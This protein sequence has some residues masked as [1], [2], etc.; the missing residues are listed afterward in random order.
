MEHRG[1]AEEDMLLE[2]TAIIEVGS[3]LAGVLLAAAEDNLEE[4]IRHEEATT[5]DRLVASSIGVEEHHRRNLELPGTLEQADIEE[6]TAM[7]RSKQATIVD[8]LVGMLE[9]AVGSLGNQLLH[10]EA[11]S[12][13]EAYSQ[14]RHL[15]MGMLMGKL[16]VGK[17]LA[18]YESEQIL[19]MHF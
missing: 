18:W 16:V 1:K 12:L 9:G 7:G 8:K 5:E 6:A 13:A 10:Q 4:G 3:I 15:L 11:S 19:Q 14:L 17:S 2:G